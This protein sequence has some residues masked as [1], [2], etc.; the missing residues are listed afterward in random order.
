MCVPVR[1]FWPLVLMI[2]ILQYPF[3][4]DVSQTMG[5]VIDNKTRKKNNRNNVH[6]KIDR[7][8]SNW[9]GSISMCPAL[10]VQIS[11]CFGTIWRVAHL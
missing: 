11:F 5:H 7:I 8:E 4:L 9:F 3:A 2:Q 10:A 6:Q 1:E